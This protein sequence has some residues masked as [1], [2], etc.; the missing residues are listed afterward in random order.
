M[1][2]IVTLQL[3]EKLNISW[4]F[5]VMAE[6]KECLERIRKDEKGVNTEIQAEC[7]FLLSS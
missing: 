7:F 6:T 2:M 1:I 3:I 5:L 4:A